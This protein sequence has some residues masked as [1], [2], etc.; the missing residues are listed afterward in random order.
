MG[1]FLF[2][3][4]KMKHKSIHLKYSEEL[5]CADFDLITSLMLKIARFKSSFSKYFSH[6]RLL[7]L[8]QPGSAHHNYAVFT[9][10]EKY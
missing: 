7:L 2:V 3:P 4:E 6:L 9:D 8:E 1:K 10:Q 5:L